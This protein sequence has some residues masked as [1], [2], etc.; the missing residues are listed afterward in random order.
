M[1]E[2]KRKFFQ[3]FKNSLTETDI[4][5]FFYSLGVD[6]YINKNDYLIFPTICHNEDIESAS[7]KLYYYKSN[8]LFH[9]YTDCGESF[10]IFGLIKRYSDTR[11]LNENTRKEITRNLLTKVNHQFQN[12]FD[13]EN[14]ISFIDKYKKIEYPELKVLPEGTLA[15]FIKYYTYEWLNEG[16]TPE[17]MDKFNILYSI[18]QNKIIIPHY[19]ENNN[20]IGV[21]GRA[22]NEEDIENG[23]YRPITI[24]E[25][26]L[27]HP[28]SLNLYGLNIN[29]LNIQKKHFA[30]IFEGE[31]SVLLMDK[32]YPE[33]TAVATCGSNLH[34]A[35]INLLIKNNVSEI[36]LAYDKEN[37]NKKVEEEYFNKLYNLC[38][39]YKHYCNF[40]FIFDRENLLADKDSPIDKG[41]EV[42]EKLLSKRVQV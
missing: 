24:E 19:D 42:F 6:N 31:K 38:N 18:T 16:I 35:Q 39:K 25:K 11:G 21:R 10:D 40:S 32:Y 37:T 7:L 4:I 22:L 23:K 29:K 13:K 8:K 28:L 30:I 15:P 26:V 33:S 2:D 5:N 34:K 36:I 1:N 17:T 3:D 27:S 20:L 41:L 9:C 14:Y 12:S